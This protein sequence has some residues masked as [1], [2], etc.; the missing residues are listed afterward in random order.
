MSRIGQTTLTKVTLSAVHIHVCIAVKVA[1]WI[2]C[3]I[4]RIRCGFIWMGSDRA[5]GGKCMVA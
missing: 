3:G 2:L 4:D 5:A 1:P